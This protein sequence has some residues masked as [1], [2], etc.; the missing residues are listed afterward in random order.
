M[1]LVYDISDGT[2]PDCMLTPEGMI[3]RVEAIGAFKW[4]TSAADDSIL[5]PSIVQMLTKM[6]LVNERQGIH[7]A[8]RFIKRNSVMDGAIAFENS[9]WYDKIIGN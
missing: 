7:I 1:Q 6:A 5:A 2:P 3:K 8:G 4:A 9:P